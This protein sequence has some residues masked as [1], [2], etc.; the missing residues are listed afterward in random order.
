MATRNDSHDPYE[1]LRHSR[2]TAAISLP[3]RP[4][5]WPT[6]SPRS[7]WDGLSTTAPARPGPWPGVGLA[8]YLPIFCFSLPAGLLADHPRRREFLRF[9]LLGQVLALLGLACAAKSSTAPLP[10]WYGL[11]FLG[12]S[13][14]AIHTPYAAGGHLLSHLDPRPRPSPIRSRLEQQQLP[15]QCH[16]GPHPGRLPDPLA[17]LGDVLPHRGRGAG[18][19]PADGVLPGSRAQS[20]PPQRQGR[21]A[22]APSWAAGT[23]C[24]MPA[25]SAGP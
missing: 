8:T 12:A 14:R 21:P 13:A 20:G 3:P 18:G 17:G 15:D 9:T 1:A 11:V 6:R 7:P 23:T 22:P 16:R 24:A 2:P 19:L 5:I 4:C 25:P 10:V